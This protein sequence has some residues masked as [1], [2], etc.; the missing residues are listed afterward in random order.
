MPTINGDITSNIVAV[1]IKRNVRVVE[2]SNT[3]NECSRHF[4]FYKQNFYEKLKRRFSL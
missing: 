4:S 2:H 1:L 3:A